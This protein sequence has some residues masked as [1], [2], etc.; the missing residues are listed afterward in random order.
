MRHPLSI[1]SLCATALVAQGCASQNSSAQGASAAVEIP[2]EGKLNLEQASAL[3]TDF[4]RGAGD[5]DANEALRQPK[6]IDDVLTILKRDQLDLFGHGT[7]FVQS[8]K[9]SQGRALHAQLELAWAE[10]ATMM[11]DAL[12]DHAE[13]L[14]ERKTD[15]ENV[16]STSAEDKEIVIELGKEIARY[17]RLGDA[18]VV[19]AEDHMKKGQT[20][21]KEVIAASPDSYHGYRV[22]ADFYRLNQDWENFDAMV[23]KIEEIKPGSNGLT[24][25]R[26]V[27]AAQR[28]FDFREAEEHFRAALEK[29]P[30]F[31]RAQMSLMLAQKNI[32][33]KYSEYI[34]LK[35]LNPNHHMVRWA[36]EAMEEDFAY[37][38]QQQ[39]KAD[40]SETP[41]ESSEDI[42]EVE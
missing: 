14:R 20:L 22:A 1:F 37:W 6:N 38:Q 25:L 11:A 36:G 2:A 23:V 7:K 31:T 41:K 16:G 15:I 32:Q 19:V 35:S 24:F 34:K 13:R 21:A 9:E 42:K 39:K 40:S 4:H 3:L 10:A 17:S 28:K 5:D 8:S 26:G 29:D 30:E 27:A 33:L 12:W 18:L